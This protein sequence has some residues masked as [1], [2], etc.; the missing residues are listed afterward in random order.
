[1]SIRFGMFSDEGDA[2]VRKAV[3][4]TI[5]DLRDGMDRETALGRLRTRT[6]A[7]IVTHDE[8]GDTDVRE[9]IAE[10]LD[11]PLTTRGFMPIE[12]GDEITA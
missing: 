11:S 9:Q 4:A 7:I 5:T 3:F 8:I 1:M 6:A 10:A 2:L 12:S